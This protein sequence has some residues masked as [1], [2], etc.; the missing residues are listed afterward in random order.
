[1]ID[2]RLGK[3]QEVL[4]DV[5]MVD[6]IITDPPYSERCHSGHD[7]GVKVSASPMRRRLAN[8]GLGRR[9]NQWR[10][11]DYER[12]TEADVGSFVSSWSPRCHG[13]LI[14]MTDHVLFQA[15]EKT[16]REAGRYVFAPVPAISTGSRFRILGDGPAC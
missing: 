10:R 5:E 2:L 6:A 16:L 1:M 14:A 8:G 13:W 4:E 12:W 3:W 15:W 11:N 9:A 7:G